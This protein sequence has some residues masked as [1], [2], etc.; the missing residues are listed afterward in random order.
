[1]KIFWYWNGAKMKKSFV[2]NIKD[3][4]IDLLNNIDELGVNGKYVNMWHKGFLI[5]VP[6][7]L[8]L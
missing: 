8:M 7:Y 1:M 2:K 4:I 6:R 3:D 5:V